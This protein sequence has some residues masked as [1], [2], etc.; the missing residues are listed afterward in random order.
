MNIED[1]FSRGNYVAVAMNSRPDDWRYYAALGLLGRTNEAIEG[2]EQYDH[3]DAR[4]YSA[5]ACWMGGDDEQAVRLLQSIQTA[6]AR[7]LLQL[8][9]KPRI[10]VLAQWPWLRSRAHNL[11]TGARQD[12]KFSVHNISFHPEDIPNEPYMD[13]RSLLH[14]VETPDFYICAMVEWHLISPH[15]QDL[16]CP[17]LGHTADYDLHIQCV[18]PWLQIF[19]ELIVTDH[20]EWADGR[21][22]AGRPVS[23]FPKS[24]AIPGEF[25]LLRF[26]HRPIDVFASGS[27]LHP[28]FAEKA[29]LFHDVLK[30]PGL[31]ALLIDGFVSEERYTKLLSQSKI[32]F[33]HIRHS[34]AMPT[35]GLEALAMGC[36][37][38]TQP[39]ST[40][41]LYVG[42]D[43]GVLTYTENRVADMIA[44]VLSA[45]EDYEQ[46]ARAG[47]SLVRGD[48]SLEKV[49]SQYLRFLTF[50][51]AR[52]REAMKPVDR[53][54]LAQKRTILRKGLS[55]GVPIYNSMRNANVSRWE[56]MIQEEAR[57][58]LFIDMERELVLGYVDHLR[59]GQHSHDLLNRALEVYRQGLESFP[60]C[61]ALRFNYVRVLFHFGSP[62]QVDQAVALA[63]ETISR[64]SYMDL[65]V[66]HDVF[67]WDFFDKYFNYRSYFD[68]VTRH[69]MHGGQTDV[70]I[71]LI[72]ASLHHYVGS[73]TR[74][75]A[76]LEKAAALDPDFPCFQFG[77]ARELM[78]TGGTADCE[79][80][81]KILEALAD[82][83]ILFREAYDTLRELY[84]EGKYISPK[85]SQL[86]ERRRR[87]EGAY[88]YVD[89]AGIEDELMGL[90][91]AYDP[92]TLQVD[93]EKT[94]W[95]S[96][97]P[98]VS[99]VFVEYFG[100]R[101]LEAV[102]SLF[103]KATG[104][105]TFEIVVVALDNS[106][107]SP[108]KERADQ[109]ITVEGNRR[110]R[111]SVGFN[112]GVIRTR[113][114]VV[115]FCRPES[116]F[117]EDYV[118]RL[119]KMFALDSSRV[120]KSVFVENRNSATLSC[121][122]IDAVIA[123][124]FDESDLSSDDFGGLYN[125]SFGLARIG[126][127][128]IVIDDGSQGSGTS[129]VVA[130]TASLRV[131]YARECR[132]SIRVRS[133]EIQALKSSLT[134]IWPLFSWEVSSKLGISG[135]PWANRLP[136]L[137]GA[138]TTAWASRQASLRAWLVGKVRQTMGL[139]VYQALGRFYPSGRQPALMYRR[140]V[141]T[142]ADSDK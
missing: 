8:I 37:V 85:W 70:C 19:D 135:F 127:H 35:R 28:Y 67:P 60:D 89:P 13:V 90:H 75:P 86:Q 43:H 54:T 56:A 81:G 120:P 87:T 4:F 51:A 32:C 62:K 140:D 106:M 39:E 34:G 111:E 129:S 108:L 97:D 29:A 99:F 31:N 83:S 96:P 136:I 59:G 107:P 138:L 55:F 134:R 105:S 88:C 57:P 141:E 68:A 53:N 92:Q 16:P 64:A 63:E 113:G 45:W 93:V 18:Y 11:I 112:V 10:V 91:A 23:T 142:S 122:K 115:T 132:N 40:L 94:T 12:T 69:S 118:E 126:S 24:F 41:G 117:Q 15:L 7:N 98:K 137:R 73:Y 42:K 14:Q 109:V 102:E 26:G 38:L 77:Y 52:P 74:D 25:D 139:R 100:R 133:A 36:V 125:L 131:E 79:N 22:L 47:A 6:H 1:Y 27:L 123:E 65:D 48:F 9:L 66:H 128:P 20:S 95:K 116:R 130:V 17:L 84:V 103:N 49:T 80:A 3:Q 82:R 2:L 33:T 78:A 124:G 72:L 71:R 104:R 119:L 5:V 50:V 61:I 44:R 110:N 114:S 101:N 30:I 58:D 76:H 121:R 21:A 46:K